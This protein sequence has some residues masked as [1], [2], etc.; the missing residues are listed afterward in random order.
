MTGNF[1]GSQLQRLKEDVKVSKHNAFAS[2]TRKN[3]HIQWKSFLLFCIYFG[4]QP[5]PADSNTVTLYVQF[6]SRSFK[7]VQSIKN[8]VSGVRFL[9]ILWD[10]EFPDVLS[11]DMKLVLRGLARLNPHCP[12]Q[13]LPISPDILIQMFS[14]LDNHVKT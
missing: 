11:V 5:L 1:A 7:S 4:L 13:A 9:H 3:L 10:L 14:F 6:L 8:Y 2:G 12:R